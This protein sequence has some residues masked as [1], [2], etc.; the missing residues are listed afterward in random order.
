MNCGYAGG[1][2]PDNGHAELRR[3][4]EACRHSNRGGDVAIWIDME[5]GL[6]SDNRFDM[7]KVRAAIDAVFSSFLQVPR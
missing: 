5:S 7:S 3:I 1:S 2:T 4:E 6:R